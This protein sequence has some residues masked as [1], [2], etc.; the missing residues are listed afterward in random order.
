MRSPLI[1]IMRRIKPSLERSAAGHEVRTWRLDFVRLTCRVVLEREAPRPIRRC[2]IARPVPTVAFWMGASH[3]SGLENTFAPLERRLRLGPTCRDARIGAGAGQRALE[4]SVEPS[5]YE[6]E[7]MGSCSERRRSGSGRTTRTSRRVRQRDARNEAGLH[8]HKGSR[9]SRM[10]GSAP[11]LQA[12]MEP[13]WAIHLQPRVGELL[14][15]WI[16]R[17]SEANLVPNRWVIGE[18]ELDG[19]I[20]ANSNV[21]AEAFE[22]LSRVTGVSTAQILGLHLSGFGI[23]TGLAYTFPYIIPA[24]TKAL[25]GVHFKPCP[26]CLK[27]DDTPYIRLLWA[28]DI[29]CFCPVHRSVL[30]DHCEKCGMQF[31]LN[32]SQ[33]R[34][35]LFECSRCEFDVRQNSV[36][37]GDRFAPAIAFQRHLLELHLNDPSHPL[38]NRSVSSSSLVALVQRLF[39]RLRDLGICVALESFDNPSFQRTVSLLEDRFSVRAKRTNA[40]SVIAW[41]MDD[42]LSHWRSLEPQVRRHPSA[43]E[44]TQMHAA[45]RSAMQTLGITNAND[46]EVNS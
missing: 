20:G 24:R 26:Q 3:T 14:E 38:G 22:S 12:A 46:R 17:L 39:S 2:R 30:L 15:S 33:R 21:S 10:N 23:T 11:I 25:E 5:R 18:L 35:R 27:S 13:A 19:F 28:L 34:A 42:P 6:P 29:T 9:G 7:T 43:V 16:V 44:G 37:S 45:F 8:E 1:Q 31:R 41:L 32:A 36:D 4:T 40:L